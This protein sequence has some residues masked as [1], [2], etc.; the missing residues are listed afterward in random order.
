MFVTFP[1]FHQPLLSAVALGGQQHWSAI[2]A[3]FREQQWYLFVYEA[4][5]IDSRVN[6]TMLV[7]WEESLLTILRSVPNRDHRALYRA[8]SEAKGTLVFKAVQK[9]WAPTL[10]EDEA[11]IGAVFEFVGQSEPVGPDL[12]P[13]P[14]KISRVLYF[15]AP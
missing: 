8:S 10:E 1:H 9:A 6:H 2:A 15:S 4:K 11:G 12:R 7:A 5:Y 13:V 3:H 14:A